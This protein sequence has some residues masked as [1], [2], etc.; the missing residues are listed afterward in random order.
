VAPFKKIIG[1]WIDE[2]D[3]VIQACC[4]VT[5]TTVLTANGKGTSTL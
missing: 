3:K 2:G 4:G 1:P 5:F